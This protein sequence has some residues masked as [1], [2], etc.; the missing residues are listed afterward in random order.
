MKSILIRIKKEFLEILPT[1]IFFLV[2]F[3]VLFVTR[4]LTLK[5][6]GIAS[7]AHAMALLGALMV[8][9]AIFIADKFP[10]LN[11]YPRRPLI[12]NVLSK[13][14]A[15]ALFTFLFLFT[16]ELV[17]Q[18]LKRGGFVASFDR[19]ASDIV[20]PVFW[21]GE[22][23]VAVLLLFYCAASELIRVVGV[24]KTKKIFFSRIR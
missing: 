19:L 15:F 4:A 13:T 10:F 9:K 5:E 16:E 6:Y 18:I 11:F 8:S 24:D 17:H 7:H 22:I 2:M 23:W 20:W 3:H 14:V 21:S 1:F 12:F